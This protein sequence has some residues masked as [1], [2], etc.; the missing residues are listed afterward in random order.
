MCHRPERGAVNHD[1]ALL[2]AVGVCVLQLE[3]LGQV[4]VYLD[5]SQLPPAS[6][7]IL[8]HEVQLRA[9]LHPRCPMH[10]PL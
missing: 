5:G 10:L 8:Y 4:V 2:A 7:G 3:A 6:N 1:R 9:V